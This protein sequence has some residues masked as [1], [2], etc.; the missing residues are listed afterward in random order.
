MKRVW[1]LVVVISIIGSGCGSGSGGGPAPLPPQQA[2]SPTNASL[3]GIDCERER[4]YVPIKPSS[5]PEAEVAALDLSVDPNTTDPRLKTI[6]LGHQGFARG[7][8]IAEKQGLVFVVSGY[9]TTTGFLDVVDETDNSL[10]AGSPFSFPTGSIPIITDGIVFDTQSDTALASMT[11]TFPICTGGPNACTGMASFDLATNSFGPLIP[12]ATS[13]NNFGFDAKTGIAIGSSDPIEPL[14]YALNL[15]GNEACTLADDSLVSLNDGPEGAAVDPDTGI[16]VVGQFNGVLTAVINLSG[17][18]FSGTPPSCTLDEFGSPP[19]NSIIFNTGAQDLL[20]GV[21]INP[22]THQAFLSGL[23]D[24]TIA[25][26]SLPKHPVQ[27][28]DLSQLSAVQASLPLEPD[29]VRFEASILPYS[30][31]IDTCHNRAYLVNQDN[32][33]MAEVNL[34]EFQRNPGA[35]NTAL[36][37]GN[38]AGTS[39]T[40]ACDNQNGVRFFP[41][42]TD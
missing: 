9:V 32:T 13:V 31:A 7:A 35:I 19:S 30:D 24:N 16:W 6:D 26:I 23:L 33:F 34:E 39:T 5:G 20:P 15:A 8:T 28:I 37:A 21:T 29:G 3:E 22:V 4:A 17:A 41:L 38:C 36:P 10:V 27:Y 14:T 40:L 2:I 11:T 12:F 42:P 1:L 18:T 25:L